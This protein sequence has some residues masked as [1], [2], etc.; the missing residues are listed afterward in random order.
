VKP[1]A[2]FHACLP[3]DLILIYYPI[4]QHSPIYRFSRARLLT[5]FSELGNEDNSEA[6]FIIPDVKS[7]STSRPCNLDIIFISCG[8]VHIPYEF[9]FFF[10]SPSLNYFN[11]KGQVGQ[12]NGEDNCS[13]NHVEGSSLQSKFMLT[14]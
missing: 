10:I 2:S 12:S 4:L 5:S 1:V 13:G 14:F 11:P 6:T 8:T 9:F 3:N 7:L